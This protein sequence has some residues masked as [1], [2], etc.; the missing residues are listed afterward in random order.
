MPLR[1]DLRKVMVIGSG[2]IIIGQAAEF[3]YAG[4]QAC[5]ALKEENIEVVLINSNPATIMTDANIA[6]RVYLE[7]LT[8]EFVA[9]VMNAERP[10]GL[11]ATLGG[12]VGLNMALQL[13]RLGYL[14]QYQVELLGT[15]LSAIQKAED[16]EMFKN[17]M[18]AIGEPVPESKVV[19]SVA[20]ALAFAQEIGY[21]VIVRPAYTLGGTGGGTAY[22]RQQLIEIASRGLRYS[23]INQLLIER[24]VGGWKEIEFEVMRDASDNCI[25]VCSMENFDPMGIHT[26]DSIV[27]APALTLNDYEFQMLRNASIRIIRA[28]QIAGGCNIQFA[29]NPSGREYYV[30]EVNPRVSRSS[31]LASKATGYPIARVT[32]KIAIGYNLDEIRNQV[33]GTTFAGFEP[34]IDYVVLK[35]PRW[36]FDK[37]NVKNRFLGTQMKATGEVMAIDRTFE[38]ALMKAVRSLDLGVVGFRTKLFTHLSD[39][40]LI[41]KMKHAEDERLFMVADGIRRGIAVE[42][43]AKAT[44]ID[45]FFVEKIKRIIEVEEELSFIAQTTQDPSTIPVEVLQ[46]AKQMGYADSELAALLN[47]TELQVREIRKKL[48]I[49]PVYKLVDTCA[50][51]FEAQT[52][53]YYSAYE[54]EN[55]SVSGGTSKV[56]V[57]GGG[58]IRIGQGIEFDYCAVHGVWALREAGRQAIIINN[59]PETVSTDF[60]T[61]DRLYFEPLVP[62]DV[63]HILELE[64]PEGVIVQFGGQTALNLA[65]PLEEAG[66]TILGTSVDDID[67]AEDRERFDQL[68]LELGIPKPPGAAATS[69]AEALAIAREIGFPVLVRP[70]Y[71]LGGRA[72]EIVY[73]EEELED[74]T[75]TAVQVNPCHPILVDKYYPGKE[76]EVDGICDGQEV[77][78][79]GIMEHVERAGVHSGDSIAVYPSFS[80]GEKEIGQ[81]VKYTEK[82]ARALKVRGFINIQFV[83]RDSEVYVL[84]VNPRASRTVPFLSKI[85]GIPMVKVATEI[86]LGKTL[87]QLGY[88]GGLY[89][90]RPYIGVKAPVFSF[91]KLLEVDVS[92]GPEMKSTG[93][94]MG[95]DRHLDTALYKALLAARMDVPRKGNLLATIADKDKEEAVPLLKEF[96]RLGFNLLATS[97][98]ASALE[99]A[100]LPVERVKKLDEGSP[101]IVDLVREGKIDFVINTLTRGKTPETDGFKIRRATVEMSIPCLTSLDTAKAVLR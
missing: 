46:R 70:S 32:T 3:D 76:V 86:I 95:F 90:G 7:P 48:K 47:L 5:K 59:N 88:Q 28:L 52:P 71:V 23:I 4:T 50:A 27:V 94:V 57:L 61:S 9:R 91:D 20:E 53:Y 93:E 96:A 98:T 36:P 17:T 8:P 42:T 30:I 54:E 39:Q 62:E 14:D 35:I 41:E 26:G 101:N 29:L 74:Y 31:A 51:E 81:I 38:S 64:Q 34:A 63:I 11:V 58:P 80:L 10:Q 73:S 16:R 82:L 89:P 24:S 77:L 75:A 85:T 15:P 12:Q 92:L 6:D 65:K 72:M 18:A 78:I 97:G 21:P 37:F 44:W 84:E 56:V 25:I 69:V 79:P 99:A 55:E 100:G 22:D 33:T 87:K 43:I 1:R 40:E 49:G 2:P 83:V 66:F 45:R 19:S 68:L 13:S 60:D 67:R